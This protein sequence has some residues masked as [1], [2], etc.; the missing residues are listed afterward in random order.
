MDM[1]IEDADV[2]A[3]HTL[4]GIG[5]IVYFPDLGQIENVI[6]SGLLTNFLR[7][8]LSRAHSIGIFG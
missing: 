7:T 3:H 4:H 5:D 1:R 8:R 2:R 6:L